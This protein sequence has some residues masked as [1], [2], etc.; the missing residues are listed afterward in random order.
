MATGNKDLLTACDFIRD[1][2]LASLGVRVDDLSLS[3]QKSALWGAAGSSAAASAESSDAD[4]TSRICASTTPETIHTYLR[5]MSERKGSRW[6]LEAP[7]TLLREK[8][9]KAK[10]ELE[11]QLAKT[12]K[13]LG[14][15]AK[16]GNKVIDMQRF[17][18]K[19]KY[20][21]KEEYLK[22]EFDKEEF[23]ADRDAKGLPVS[24]KNG[25]A[26]PK[27]TMKKLEKNMGK[28][29]EDRAKLLGKLGLKEDSAKEDVE[30]ARAKE[31][32]AMKKEIERLRAKA[33]D[34][35]RELA[36]IEEGA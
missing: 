11:Q 7:D 13:A 12:E 24:L 32:G 17:E 20:Y 3:S 26:I 25:E 33:A 27:A 8:R 16:P 23:A 9:E 22:A 15:D 2:T 28:Y 36:E 31:L 1:E 19:T 14:T 21:D 10:K 30:A 18:E 6:N 34:L 29:F 5:K 4:S 35:E